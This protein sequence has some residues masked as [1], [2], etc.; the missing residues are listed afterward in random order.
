MVG[1]HAILLCDI[2]GLS[3]VMIRMMVYLSYSKDTVLEVPRILDIHVGI[4][5]VASM[6]WCLMKRDTWS[7]F[8]WGYTI[9]Q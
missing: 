8:L 4:G 2:G 5:G 7:K 3:T 6:Q 1:T 9:H